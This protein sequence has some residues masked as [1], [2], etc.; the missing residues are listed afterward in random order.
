VLLAFAACGD[1]R[2]ATPDATTTREVVALPAQANRELDVLF[3]LDNEESTSDH[4]INLLLAVPALIAAIS[5]D[6]PPDLHLGVIT[7]DMGSSSVNGT[8]P[9]IGGVS[10]GGCFGTGDRGELY[11]HRFATDAVGVREL[12]FVGSDGCGFQQPLAAMR[13]AFTNPSNVGF[14]R[15]EAA[16]GVIVIADEDDCSALDPSLFDPP[17]ATLGALSHFRC[18][19]FGL[20]CA[21]PDMT[22][23]G[24]RTNCVP[25]TDSV[26]IEDP[27]DF[28]NVLRS[29]ATDPRRV[30]F[31]AVVGPSDVAI[32]LMAPPGMTSAI[33]ATAHTCEWTE[34]NSIVD[35][36]ESLRL[37]W[38]ANQFGD[39]GAIGSICSEDLTPAAAALGTP[40]R[41]AMGD[42]CVEDDGPLTACTAVDQLGTTE[43]PLAHCET[44]TQTDC[45]ELVTDPNVCP[46]AAHQKLVVHRRD[47][48]ADGT[49]T[50]LRCG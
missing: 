33:P 43:T 26:L 46:S 9:G 45:W 30:A 44:P 8:A 23:P 17:S 22:S 29:Q 6:G 37:S 18:A 11:M 48:V 24:P 4:Q 36:D 20:T 1:N 42:P 13:A 12:F 10:Q 27:A 49:Y 38:F 50:L 15:P 5:L 3:V 39:H 28:V 35:A 21:E 16:L 47:A 25:K 34:D 41:R 7:P 31:G 40:L 32:E 19:Q 14:R 2:A